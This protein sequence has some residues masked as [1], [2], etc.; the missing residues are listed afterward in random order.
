M[1]SLSAAVNN[2][3]VAAEYPCFSHAVS[4]N[5]DQVDV[6]RSNVEKLIE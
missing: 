6:G 5:P 1:N 3:K 4:I 2:H